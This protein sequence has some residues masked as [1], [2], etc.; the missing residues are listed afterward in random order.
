MQTKSFLPKTRW[1]VTI[2]LLLSLGI[3]NAWGGTTVSATLKGSGSSAS[4]TIT[5]G[6]SSITWTAN[7]SASFAD[8]DSKGQ[9]AWTCSS[10][11]NTVTLTSST[12]SSY[13]ITKVSVTCRRNKAYSITASVTVGGNAY[14]GDAQTTDGEKGTNY[15]LDFTNATGVT[16]NIVITLTSGG[17][18]SQG[19]LMV[20]DLTIIYETASCSADPTIG[21][22]SL[23]GAF[24]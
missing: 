4:S 18:S 20:T 13:K 10:A 9:A 7:T 22:A 6:T 17:G 2:I 21:S 14:G 5:T 19:S 12:F 16:G 23:N 24:N 1:L 15:T 8:Y 3:T 11:T